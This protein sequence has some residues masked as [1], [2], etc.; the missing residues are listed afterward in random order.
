M[1]QESMRDR[2]VQIYDPETMTITIDG[3]E[4]EDF[5]K[6]FSEVVSVK[7]FVDDC[8]ESVLKVAETYLENRRSSKPVDLWE[9]LEEETN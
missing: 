7:K 5:Y 6:E 2:R 1:L 4:L 8:I 9:E 3:R